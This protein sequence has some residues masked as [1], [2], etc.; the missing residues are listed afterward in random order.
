M[1]IICKGRCHIFLGTSTSA[2]PCESDQQQ[3]KG[4]RRRGEFRVGIKQRHTNQ[5]KMSVNM[6]PYKFLYILTCMSRCAV[7]HSSL[8]VVGK[9]GDD[10]DN[11]F[12]CSMCKAI[13]ETAMASIIKYYRGLYWRSDAATFP[14]QI[15]STV[16]VVS[17]A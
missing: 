10:Y 13:S 11:V 16:K 14:R 4:K 6:H 3:L 9:T 5:V 1:S 7:L 2:C 8:C 12:L 15:N 17:V